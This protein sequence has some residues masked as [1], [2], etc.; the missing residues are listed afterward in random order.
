VLTGA[1]NHGAH[2]DAQ[3]PAHPLQHARQTRLTLLILLILPMLLTGHAPSDRLPTSQTVEMRRSVGTC[4]VFMQ[5]DMKMR[6]NYFLVVATLLIASPAMADSW[7]NTSSNFCLDTDGRA[8]NGGAVRMWK[9]QP[10]PNQQWTLRAVGGRT[11][12]LINRSS[13]FCLD[14]DGSRTNGGLV[15]VW[16]CVNHPNQLWEIQNLLGG[17]SRLINRASGFCLDSDGAAVNGGAVRMW[18]CVSHPHQTWRRA[19]PIDI[20]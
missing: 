7:I 4:R 8:V 10:H 6:V 20:D 12:R 13:N 3:P 17:N 9:C 2:L 1:R 5:G 14:T 16:G 18:Q 15:R 19:V 11:F